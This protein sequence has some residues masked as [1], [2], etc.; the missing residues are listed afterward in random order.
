MSIT[1]LPPEISDNIFYRFYPVNNFVPTSIRPT[2]LP[3]HY[4][5]LEI[6]AFERTCKEIIKGDKAM[7]RIAHS[8]NPLRSTAIAFLGVRNRA[9]HE[10]NTTWNEAIWGHKVWLKNLEHYNDRYNRVR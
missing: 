7:L 2:S 4:S 8:S 10:S 6:R 3:R 5:A 9:L 1:N